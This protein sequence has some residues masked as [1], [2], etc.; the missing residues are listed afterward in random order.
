MLFM[1]VIRRFKRTRN[2][3][4]NKVMSQAKVDQYKKEK[5]NRKKTMQKEKF[6]RTLAAV[7]GIV[8]V[9]AICVWAGFSVYSKA[10]GSS[11][12][13]DTATVSVNTDAISDYMSSLD[14][15]E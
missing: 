8:I 11:D 15:A 13:T 1:S 12:T 14:D 3:G 4:E 10:T 7:C 6:E 9:A 2:K 5:A